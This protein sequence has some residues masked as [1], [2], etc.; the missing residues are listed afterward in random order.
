M[1]MSVKDRTFSG[2]KMYIEYELW[3]ACKVFPPLLWN[4]FTV[5]SQ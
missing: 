5:F 2:V 1:H 3:Q 4:Y